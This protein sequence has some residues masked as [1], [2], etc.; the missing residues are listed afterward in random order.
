MKLRL[1]KIFGKRYHICFS[2]HILQMIIIVSKLKAI[3]LTA[4]KIQ[5]TQT[6]GQS[7]H[8]ISSKICE[9]EKIVAFVS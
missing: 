5:M 6:L 8:E 9:L 3:F 2:N 7:L 4:K 1:F